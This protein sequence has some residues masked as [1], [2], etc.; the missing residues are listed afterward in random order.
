MAPP[1]ASPLAVPYSPANM[2]LHE[3]TETGDIGGPTSKEDWAADESW[4][5]E[6]ADGT[7]SEATESAEDFEEDEEVSSTPKIE[8]KK[9]PQALDTQSNTLKS[10]P[11]L[12]IRG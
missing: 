12:D 5:D 10:W 11:T 6:H 4:G 7:V 2:R 3:V 1:K 9:R 8:V